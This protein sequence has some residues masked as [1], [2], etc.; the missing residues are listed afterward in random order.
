MDKDLKKII[1]ESLNEFFGQVNESSFRIYNQTLCP[2]LWDEYQHLDPR[3]R[4]NLLRMAYDFYKKTEFVA[5]IVDVWLMGSIANYNWTPESDADVHIIIDFSQLKMPPETASKV[6]KSAGAAWNKDHNVTVKGHK[7]EINIQSVKAEKPYVMGIYSLVKD[8]WIKKP[9]R[10][11]LQVNKPLIQEKYSQ[12]K[13]YIDFSM[14]SGNREEMKK[15]KDYLDD[16]RQYGLDHGGELS[17]ENIVYKILRSKGLVKAL[18]DAITATYDKE[19]TV[20]ETN[21]QT[22]P[23]QTYRDTMA[24]DDVFNDAERYFAIGH[25]DP[26]EPGFTN[27]KGYVWVWDGNKIISK[28]GT[29][30]GAAFSHEVSD[31]HFKGRFDPEK[32]AISV[33]FPEYELRKLGGNRPTVDDIPQRV[34]QKLL[35]TF[36]TTNPRFEVFEDT[37]TLQEV[38]MKDLKQNLPHSPSQYKYT[39]SGELELGNL[40]LDNLAALRAKSARSIAY[41]R[42]HP[43]ENPDWMVREMEEFKRI[44]QEMKRRLSYINAPVSEGTDPD[45]DAASDFHDFKRPQK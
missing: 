3:V 38:G 17:V 14:Q 20:A 7:V 26:D 21:L 42:K 34:Y 31:R 29:T 16:F 4:V 27:A 39:D 8:E 5:P 10:M 44:S 19:M 28:R 37:Q 33:V 9:C 45:Y 23:A 18:K 36:K 30:H 15:A 1:D 2:D 40:T 35:S 24:D 41:L 32:N 13:K 12:L 43:E 22:S 25:D 6:A 11:N